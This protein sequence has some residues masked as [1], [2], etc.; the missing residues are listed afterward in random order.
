MDIA[1]IGFPFNINIKNP[2][3]QYYDLLFCACIL[4]SGIIVVNKGI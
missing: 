3:H 4:L 2:K 1:G